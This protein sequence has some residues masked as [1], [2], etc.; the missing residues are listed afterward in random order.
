MTGFPE[1][2]DSTLA[3][4]PDC[5]QEHVWTYLNGLSYEQIIELLGK[6]KETQP[7][8]HL[9]M[10]A[11]LPSI[12]RVLDEAEK[13]S[14]EVVPDGEPTEDEPV[15]TSPARDEP[16]EDE[17]TNRRKL[18][19]T[20]PALGLWGD[21]S[22]DEEE[23]EKKEDEPVA[24]PPAAAKPAAT[25]PVAAPPAAA[26]PVSAPSAATFPTATFPAAAAPPATASPALG[27]LY[28]FPGL[29]VATVAP[30]TPA[31]PVIP[32]A[33]AAVKP[34]AVNYQ[35]DQEGT[36]T[37][38]AWLFK[39]DRAGEPWYRYGSWFRQELGELNGTPVPL[40]WRRHPGGWY[41]STGKSLFKHKYDERQKMWI[42]QTIAGH[43][44][45]H[46]KYVEEMWK[47]REMLKARRTRQRQ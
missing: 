31:A 8:K 10:M 41:T 36:K 16:T 24:A 47:A 35:P 19:E 42:H 33:P 37:C 6:M 44:V 25:K 4:K 18:R 28:E 27:C 43:P 26:K 20:D 1:F 30:V 22:D 7:M 29:N 17:S 32:A 39:L 9:L 5:L 13:C 3:Q 11:V 21:E 2:V 15:A 46:D 38:L 12:Y 23:E 14:T 45:T 40:G 34:I